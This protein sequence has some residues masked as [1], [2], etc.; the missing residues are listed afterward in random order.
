M[1]IKLKDCLV[2]TKKK[3]KKEVDF[4]EGSPPGHR[5]G[6]CPLMAGPFPSAP[7][8]A[9]TCSLRSQEIQAPYGFTGL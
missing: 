3:K 2:K 6:L 7:N 9:Y 1:I 8:P 5:H 4:T